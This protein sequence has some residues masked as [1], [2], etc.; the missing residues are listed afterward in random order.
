MMCRVAWVTVALMAAVSLAGAQAPW[1]KSREA[2]AV[3]AARAAQ[4]TAI[5]KR[6]IDRTA[7]Y[8]SPDIV[9]T[10]GLGRVIRGRDEYRAAFAAD[11]ALL[12][13]REP[14]RIDVAE[15]AKWPL[16][17]ETGS[18]TGRVAAYTRP[19]IRGRYSAQWQKVDGQWRIRS[20]VF[21][22][23]GCSPP[24]CDWPVALR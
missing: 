2:A 6:D 12:Y 11:S 14:E 15:N 19:L 18:W 16:A 10:A 8:W 9:V 23:L 22:A 5:A 3:R 20:E 17:F 21:V 24:A 1:S 4:N 13:W 7:S